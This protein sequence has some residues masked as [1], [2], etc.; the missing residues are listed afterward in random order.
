MKVTSEDI[1]KTWKKIPCAYCA[2][3]LLVIIY[4]TFTDYF[5]T[6]E[7]FINLVQQATLLAILSLGMTLV[8]LTMGID[9]SAG[10]IATLCGVVLAVYLKSGGSLLGAAFILLA[11]GAAAGVGHGFFFFFRR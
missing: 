11:V 9:L 3:I 2:V 7:N 1:K 6:V 5:L 10:M 4:T 8:M